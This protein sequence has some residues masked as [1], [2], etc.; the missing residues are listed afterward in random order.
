VPEVPGYINPNLNIFSSTPDL[1][2]FSQKTDQADD[3]YNPNQKNADPSIP[4]KD[5]EILRQ[6][7]IYS[8][9]LYFYLGLSNGIVLSNNKRTANF[10]TGDFIEM[11]SDLRKD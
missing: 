9:Y 8:I 6:E 2:R 3:F 1:M 4:A 7:G 10:E 5:I 11:Y